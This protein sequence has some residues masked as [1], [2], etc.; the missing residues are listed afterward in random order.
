VACPSP[1][2]VPMFAVPLKDGGCATLCGEREF[3]FCARSKGWMFPRFRF[4]PSCWIESE[5]INF[6]A[7]SGE[8]VSAPRL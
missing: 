5:P 1:Q 4:S 7:N 6:R 3:G 8:R 2:C